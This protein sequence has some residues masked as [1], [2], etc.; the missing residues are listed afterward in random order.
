VKVGEAQS[1]DLQ[2]ENLFA[3]RSA[4]E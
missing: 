2:S 1:E 4:C 3:L